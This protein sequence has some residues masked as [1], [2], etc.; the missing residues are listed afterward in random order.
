MRP[1][2]ISINSPIEDL[3]KYCV[4]P[5]KQNYIIEPNPLIECERRL[6]KKPINIDTV[7]FTKN[8]AKNNIK[9]ENPGLFQKITHL[10]FPS[11]N[12]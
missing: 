8:T 2:E 3:I 11:P 4:S 1:K 7:E 5:V 6:V 9:P 10:L 12:I